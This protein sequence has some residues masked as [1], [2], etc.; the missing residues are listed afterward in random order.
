MV[1]LKYYKINLVLV[2]LNDKRYVTIA[3]LLLKIMVRH[4]IQQYLLQSENFF[5]YARF[6]CA[7]WQYEDRK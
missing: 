6:D 5:L 1:I 2:K 7:Y 3:Y 4:Y